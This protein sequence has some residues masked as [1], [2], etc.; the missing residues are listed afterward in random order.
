V[1]FQ[2]TTTF[3]GRRLTR[4]LLLEMTVCDCAR[5][6]DS[7]ARITSHEE[8]GS[9]RRLCHMRFRHGSIHDGSGRNREVGELGRASDELAGSI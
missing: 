6:A 1:S 8:R 5:R 2:L 7:K 4:L 3:G 9:W